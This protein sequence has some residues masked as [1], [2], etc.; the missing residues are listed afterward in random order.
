MNRSFRS[1]PERFP[2]LV[3]VAWLG[4]VLASSS[5]AQTGRPVAQL[6][7]LDDIMQQALSRY[8]VK[9]GA[10]AIIKDG[11][12][13]FAR[14]YGL[15]DAEAGEPVQPDSLFRWESMSK[16]VTASAV[17]RLVED[18]KLDLD[19]PV[20]SI[21]NQ[22]TP[23]NGRWG[24][25]RLFWI[26]VRQLLQHTGG[27]DRLISPQADPVDGDGTIKAASATGSS[28]P[29]SIDTVIRYMLAQRLDFD[30]GARWAY[31]PFGYELLGRVIEKVSGEPYMQFIHDR[32]LDPI[33]LAG[34]QKG[35]ATLQSRLP[36]EVKYY[37]YPGAAWI[38]SYVSAAREMEPR[39]YGFQSFDLTDSAGA[40]VGSV[41]DIAKFVAELDGARL[42]GAIRADS[43]PSM[44]R[45][46][47]PAT[48]IDYSAWYGFGLYVWSRPGGQTWGHGGFNPGA[49]T[50]FY[51]WPDGTGC[52]FFFNTT[53]T[54][55]DPVG[56][57]NDVAPAIPVALA[58]V[59]EWPD[60]DL[61]PAYYPPRIAAAGVVNAASFEPGPVAPGSLITILGS[62]LGGQDAGA[63]VSLHDSSG[64]D[65]VLPLTYSGPGQ[66]N[67]FV[68]DE[69]TIG[70]ATFAVH[71]AGWPDAQVAVTIA[72]TS[73]GLFAMNSSGLAA[74]Y[75]VRNKL[76]ST[77]SW[78]PVFQTDQAGQLVAK[79]I[80]FGSEDEDLALVFYGTGVCRK[81]RANTVTV[82]LGDLTMSADYAGRHV[83][84]EGLDQINVRLP[85]SLADAGE[86]QIRV[87]V[88]GIASN[89]VRV[90][91]RQTQR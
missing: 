20:F 49:Q 67:A 25:S 26:T 56:A 44:L 61:F 78:E 75:A 45:Q 74:A 46:S 42:P 3:A 88:N 68:P 81:D 71:R 31:A 30:P 72:G 22:Y 28:F 18:G 82:H 37:D 63:I 65:R 77:Q 19:T 48:W 34:V 70:D 6:S 24:D 1:S 32:V 87:E 73:P 51:R 58:A 76:G 35:G 16:T 53:G 9:G 69:S 54:D 66:L 14:G 13:I 83:D 29:P 41:V 84:Y 86:V 17:L 27:W 80:A 79:A 40:L 38:R 39:P 59:T 2:N 89:S 85:R 36:K 90:T 11:R 62:D 43:F 21:L 55:S 5:L 91:F 64:A 12:L 52:A 10:L 7:V 50:Y 60:H 4:I 47:Q 57:S 15:A 8:S 33:G 23:Y